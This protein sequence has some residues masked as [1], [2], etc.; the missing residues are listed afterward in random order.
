M[1]VR[2]HGT[3]SSVTTDNTDD[4]AGALDLDGSWPWHPNDTVLVLTAQVPNL[5]ATA[6][7]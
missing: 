4:L 6:G 7:P 5:P 1:P 2:D 3:Y